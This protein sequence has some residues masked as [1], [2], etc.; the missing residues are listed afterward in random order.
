MDMRFLSRLQNP[1][2][3]GE[4][5]CTPCTVLNSLIAVAAAGGVALVSPALAVATLLG[6]AVVITL[7]GYLVPGT[8][9]LTKR[10]L[11][12]RV[13][14]WF[15]KTPLPDEPVPTDDRPENTDTDLEALLSEKGIVRPCASADD[16]CLSDAVRETWLAHLRTA[17]ECSPE[18]V[19]ELTD[20]QAATY[21]IT[22]KRG[23]VVAYD[24]GSEVGRWPSEAALLAD[25]TCAA[26]MSEHYPGW[27]SLSGER[28]GELLSTLR[29]F[30]PECPRASGE[31][32]LTTETVETCC[33][34]QEVVALQC[35]ETGTNL[36][37]HPL[38]Q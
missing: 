33:S 9:T 28:R 27:A 4:N 30:T 13:L 31:V 34:A 6:S 15:G 12:R 14:A 35:V 16:L 17:D 5:R 8:P 29:F 3:T 1:E 23:G 26:T 20:D 10:Y 32:E 37:R 11:P 2:Y 18:H 25:A 38:R 21:E 36:A 19:A 22:E 7:R 24:G